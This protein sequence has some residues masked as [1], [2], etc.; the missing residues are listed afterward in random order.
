MADAPPPPPP[1]MT[2]DGA[3]I[4]SVLSSSSHLTHQE[5]MARRSRRLKQLSTIY[6]GHYWAL[7]EELKSKYKEYYWK[8]GKSPFKQDDKKRKRSNDEE[9]SGNG[10]GEGNGKLGLGEEEKEEDYGLRK[11]AVGGCKGTAMV[12]TKFCHQHILLDSKQKLYKS[13][14]FVVKSTQGRP[15]L[16]GKPV[17][18]STVPALCPPHFQKA[19][20]Y[21]ARDL[22]KAGLNNVSSSNK[23][24][25]KFHVVVSE[26]VHQIQSKRR[27]ARKENVPKENKENKSS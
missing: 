14:S 17:L 19:E 21:V 2:I 20:L 23:V 22:R 24:A 1:P 8:Y 5:L 9:N 16:C 18:R 6:R 15:I 10:I 7:M 26:F 12:L 27:T 13:C 4:D 11:C 25:P 3:H